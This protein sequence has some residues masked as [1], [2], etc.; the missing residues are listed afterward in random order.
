MGPATIFEES[1]AE[2]CVENLNS[3]NTS[4]SVVSCL[5]NPTPSESRILANEQDI[6][7]NYTPIDILP[8][9][10]SF[11]NTG[12]NNSGALMA[13]SPPGTS[14]HY[15]TILMDSAKKDTKE[16]DSYMIMSPPPP[17]QDQKSNEEKSNL[18][19]QHKPLMD[20]LANHE[21][22]DN[23]ASSVTSPNS[24][25]SYNPLMDEVQTDDSSAYVVMSPATSASSGS[26]MGTAPRKISH[27]RSG[28]NSMSKTPSDYV[29]MS[30]ASR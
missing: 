4:S 18:L 12:T 25:S 11:S 15:S 24:Q 16:S 9:S 17:P 1:S 20:L 6:N 30:P 7:V 8:S 23:S 3:V 10:S 13:S 5:K 29:D 28:S 27:Q 14:V 22:E 21:F 26:R 2:S 19:R